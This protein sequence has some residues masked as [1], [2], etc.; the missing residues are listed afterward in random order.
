MRMIPPGGGLRQSS[1]VPTT[2]PAIPVAPD[3]LH[4]G[5]LVRDEAAAI[6][7]DELDLIATP[8]FSARVSLLGEQLASCRCRCRDSV[9]ACP[10]H[11]I[12]PNRCEVEHSGSFPDAAPRR[13]GE[14]SGVIGCGCGEHFQ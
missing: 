5:L 14:L 10:V 9:I 7:M 13:G 11:S 8:S 4:T 12:S 1:M 6:A 3:R 2:P